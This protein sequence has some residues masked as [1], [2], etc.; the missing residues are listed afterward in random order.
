M[1][2]SWKWLLVLLLWIFL[3]F[4][5]C[6]VLTFRLY[7]CPWSRSKFRSES[8]GSR[9]EVQRLASVRGASLRPLGK[10]Q[11]DWRSRSDLR[12]RYQR[13]H[14]SR[15][16]EILQGLWNGNLSVQ[17]LSPRLQKVL[18]VQL[19]SNRYQVPHRMS[20]GAYRS[21]PQLYCELKTRTRVQTVDGTEEPFSSLNWKQLVP[22]QP[23]QQLH[24]FQSCAV[25]T[26]AGSIL[27][28]SLGEEIGKS[29]GVRGQ[30]QGAGSGSGGRA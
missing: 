10:G 7:S 5:F 13:Y 17:M 21:G 9:A 28:S 2:S 12:S 24:T 14:K 15:S 16:L 1:K 11:Q 29:V 20:G 30:G 23:L 26:S 27:N 4:L 25:V 3:W 8:R 22:P 6:H 19:N 18:Q